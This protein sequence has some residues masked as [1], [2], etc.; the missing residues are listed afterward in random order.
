MMHQIRMLHE[1]DLTAGRDGSAE[2]RAFAE[3]FQSPHRRNGGQA[4]LGVPGSIGRGGPP[5]MGSARKRKAS[6]QLTSPRGR[7]VNYETSPPPSHS[8]PHMSSPPPFPA[9]T[10]SS[11]RF[12]D[13]ASRSST[14][15]P[16]SSHA[17]GLFDLAHQTPTKSHS[18]HFTHSQSASLSSRH[19]R[20]PD[21][22]ARPH[23]NASYPYSQVAKEE[24]EA[25]IPS[26][27]SSSQHP[28][29][30]F[31]P[32][33]NRGAQAA[34]SEYGTQALPNSQYSHHQ[35][36][37]PST[38]KRGKAKKRMNS[39][40][41]SSASQDVSLSAANDSISRAPSVASSYV[42]PKPSQYDSKTKPPF[43]Y[44]ALI[45]QAI[46]STPNARMSLADIYTYIMTVYPF[47]KK[48]DAGWQN[49][50]RHNLSL[51]ECFV[52]TQ[53]G[54]DEPGKGCLWAIQPGC[55]EQFVDGNFYKKGKIP[56]SASKSNV[57]AS[58]KSL[59]EESSSK[60][61]KKK[62]A[63]APSVGGGR[64][65]VSIASNE[66][67][68]DS[69]DNASFVSASS[70]MAHP[71]PPQRPDPRHS[72]TEHQRPTAG[73]PAESRPHPQSR[74]S[75]N[76]RQME[77]EDIY[78]EEDDSMDMSEQPGPSS[79]MDQITMRR[80]AE[81]QHQQ[82]MEQ[83]RWLQQ[84]QQ[85]QQAQRDAAVAAAASRRTSRHKKVVRGRNTVSLSANSA[86]MAFPLGYTRTQ[87]SGSQLRHSMVRQDSSQDQEMDG[88]TYSHTGYE[89]GQ[90]LTVEEDKSYAASDRSGSAEPAS[91]PPPRH[92]IYGAQTSPVRRSGTG[93]S[94]RALLTSPPIMSSPPT[95]VFARMSQP[96]QPLR[97]AFNIP[98]QA[99]AHAAA[100]MS[101]P[102]PSGIMPSD[103]RMRRLPPPTPRSAARDEEHLPG[104]SIFLPAPNIRPGRSNP[105]KRGA[106]K[107]DDDDDELDSKPILPPIHMMSPASNLVP[108]NTQSP[109]SSIRG[110][111]ANRST[112]PSPKS[113]TQ[114]ST[115]SS[116]RSPTLNKNRLLHSAEVFKTP[117]RFG[118]PNP[119]SSSRTAS[120]SKLAHLASNN[121]SKALQ[122]LQYNSTPKLPGSRGMN[123]MVTPGPYYDP[124]EYG[125]VVDEELDRMAKSGESDE[126][127][128]AGRHG[129][130]R[131]LPFPS[132][133]DRTPKWQP[134]SPW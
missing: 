40:A 52:K 75:Y 9:F 97:D 38:G 82:T 31:I 109:V 103:A 108:V 20:T 35:L 98:G 134:W 22:Q 115:S 47:Y 21:G 62:A 84:H 19:G 44:A 87:A 60:S 101:S 89:S 124:Y 116:Q 29:P 26:L 74:A 117:D 49:S 81:E 131:P 59:A 15:H 53:R 43:S 128:G 12:Y 39:V 54:P 132:P 96:Y 92:P 78:E 88:S 80:Q 24:D 7:V 34:H 28:N 23:D 130:R 65:N 99:S 67:A 104:S 76:S 6:Y 85:Q 50:I 106:A 120:P 5:E 100:L 95:N 57:G 11:P 91:G 55:E 2:E 71:Q 70:S 30:D 119:S 86:D 126:R 68:D 10:T 58:N 1:T 64:E 66:A 8:P 45:G 79:Q 90:L 83:A 25:D 16:S 123:G 94:R 114:S 17:A 127:P 32:Y 18:H 77:D 110:S 118:P 112:S 27:P 72:R 113:S 125:A 102:P 46:F 111:A 14:A 107:G 48:Q 13:S 41:S 42:P 56:K 73:P 36:L 69:F 133:L 4:S 93:P 51:N 63:R 37:P 3:Q 122:S 33:S 61:S 105:H 121:A 129:D